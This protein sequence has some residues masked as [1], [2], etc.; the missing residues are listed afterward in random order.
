LGQNVKYYSI[1]SNDFTENIEEA[2][3][4]D[5]TPIKGDGTPYFEAAC[6]NNSIYHNNFIGNNKNANQALI[7][8]L[9]SGFRSDRSPIFLPGLANFWDDG[10]RGNYWSDYNGTGVEPYYINENNQDNHP[11][12]SPL[13]FSALKMPS[14]E[15]IQN[16]ATEQT[17][18]PLVLVAVAVVAFLVIAVFSLLVYFKKRKQQA[19]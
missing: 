2:I 5:A 6:T 15:P 10:A 7:G 11:L 3:K 17:T 8:G 19:K 4:F 14:T 16:K 13:V 9:V 1:I 18:F 12:P